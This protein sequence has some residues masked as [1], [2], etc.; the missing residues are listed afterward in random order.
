MRR[1][2]R[3][4]ATAPLSLSRGM[5]RERWAVPALLAG[6]IAAV[7]SPVLLGRS[8]F[9]YYDFA[10]QDVPNRILL[11]S[12]LRAADPAPLLWNPIIFSGYPHFAETQM[13]A[14]YI[15]DWL[16]LLLMPAVSA[17]SFSYVAHYAIAGAGMYRFARALDLCRPAAWLAALAFLFSG[18]LVGALLAGQTL[19][20]YVWLPWVLLAMERGAQ[21]GRSRWWLA[22][23][24]LYALQLVAGYPHAALV[25]G[26]AIAG[27]GLY[28]A[29]QLGLERGTR[30]GLW[31][32][33]ALIAVGA[34]AA[35]LASAQLMPLADLLLQSP[36]AALSFEAATALSLPPH[37]LLTLVWPL[38]YYDAGTHW[39][40]S[41]ANAGRTAVY[42]GVVPLALA[43]AGLR[44]SLRRDRRTGFFAALAVVGVVLAL[45][46]H[47]PVYRLVYMLPLS[48]SWRTPAL[49]GLLWSTCVAVLAGRGAHVALADPDP[50]VR[51]S[52]RRRAAWICGAAGVGVLLLASLVQHGVS[53][54]ALL[55]WIARRPTMLNPLLDVGELLDA[56]RASTRVSGA[57]VLAPAIAGL[58]GAGVLAVRLP[59]RVR[60][61]GVLAI[62]SADLGMFAA[63]ILGATLAP[64][65]AVPVSAPIETALPTGASRVATP[66]GLY[67]FVDSYQPNS[68]MAREIRTLQGYTP[69]S[70]D[71]YV[72]F[73]SVARQ[74]LEG[75][76]LAH[77]LEV[78]AVDHAIDG[79]TVTV[80]G[81]PVV[82]G[83]PLTVAGPDRT[84]E[85]AAVLPV[86][87]GARWDDA[88][89][90]LR[91]TGSA[92]IPDD[93]TV[94]LVGR[95]ETAP[96]A[97]A[98]GSSSAGADAGADGTIRQL[99]ASIFENPHVWFEAQQ[100]RVSRWY[101]LELGAIDGRRVGGVRIQ[102]HG[103]ATTVRTVGFAAREGSSPVLLRALPFS[104]PGFEPVHTADRRRVVRLPGA[105]PRAW[106]AE[107]V[108]I[109]EDRAAVEEALLDPDFEP[110]RTTN[111]ELSSAAGGA[112]ST[113]E[114]L[115]GRGPAGEARIAVEHGGHLEVLVEARRPAILVVADSL[116]PG[117]KATVDGEPAP[118]LRADLRF[119]AVVVP[120]GRHAVVFDYAPAALR[121][122]L[123]VS[124]ASVLLAFLALIWLGRGARRP[125]RRAPRTRSS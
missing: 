8:V 5:N 33:G 10:L 103:P 122:G 13:A 85:A 94:D 40:W 22:A 101:F 45:G 35:G 55:A 107:D 66:F 1:G 41:S 67:P 71:Q 16:P 96:A 84:R 63:T 17:W 38:A 109:H 77:L 91:V 98:W 89:L 42:A 44:T 49:Y 32:V 11:R 82:V 34:L 119:R 65:A 15:P 18:Q 36:R 61:A 43:I 57:G 90:V 124:G 114:I 62:V 104:G 3:G 99:P 37:G 14:L 116:L 78:A 102:A 79:D 31:R 60:A 115:S 28:R 6:L 106:L 87:E 7:F 117:V 2:K 30:A 75:P 73:M 25:S 24:V 86:P 112:A 93:W 95:D 68:L 125:L 9:W 70:T 81:V 88:R 39:I 29:V 47:T 56:I 19:R 74:A 51:R 100:R 48:S 12:A 4:E 121:W 59:R 83:W 108:R 72:H 110:L 120:A 20:T 118:I 92:R 26:I 123:I 80:D 50:G 27:Y 64:A 21:T 105:R 69:L 111:V 113:V 23:A 54:S 53:D 76:G 46:R 58:A 52:V 97:R